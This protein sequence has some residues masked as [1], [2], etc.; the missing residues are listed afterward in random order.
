MA[1]FD[2]IILYCLKQLNGERTIY[3]VYHLLK[4]KKS[5]QTIQDAHLFSLTK[6]FG[7]FM[8]LTRSSLEEA[9]HSMFQQGY[10]LQSELEPQHYTLTEKGNAFLELLLKERSL[11]L[12]LEGLKYQPL[13]QLVWERI[14]L[15]VQVVSN[16]VYQEN[17]YIPIQKGKE[18]HQWLKHVLRKHSMDRAEIGK[19]LFIELTSCLEKGEGLNPLVLSL[20]L[21]GHQ[22]IGL[23]SMQAADELK[24][25]RTDYHI[26]FLNLLHFLIQDLEKNPEG[27]S[28]LTDLLME[29]D[30]S[31]ALTLSS[32]KTFELLQRGIPLE[33]LPSIRR[34]KKSTIE[35]HIVEIALNV[36]DFPIHSFVKKEV[37][38]EIM[39]A[40]KSSPTRQLKTIRES[41]PQANY[42]EIRLVLAKLGE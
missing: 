21:T 25:E 42:F 9:V 23:T 32:R 31:L 34:L 28:I 12:Y 11:P 18:T 41:V 37:Q 7:V 33:K 27:Y 14:S 10:I 5:A 30:P 29:T 36:K 35:D 39:D 38:G 24:M 15:L 2:L 19:K 8:T 13:T 22:I 17:K 20:R 26:E 40:A 4:G 1:Y 6:F 16:L 3:S